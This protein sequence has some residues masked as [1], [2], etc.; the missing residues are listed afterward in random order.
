M[1]TEPKL[2]RP[3]AVLWDMDG[4]LIDQTAAI[5]ECYRQVIVSLGH[6]S[7]D[8]DRIRRSLGGPM[9]STMGLFIEEAQMDEACRAF[10]ALFPSIM[11]EGLI[12]LPGALELIQAFDAAG[13]PQGILTNKH[14]ETARIVSEHCGFSPYMKACIGNTDTEW[15][16]PQAELTNYVLEQIGSSAAGACMIGDSPTDVETAGNAGLPCYTVATGAHTPEELLDSGAA[17]AGQSLHAL[18]DR[19]D[20]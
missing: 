13:I 6:P 19:I 20:W 1:S 10:R 15:H 17:H 14:G 12:I 3:S 11:F 18:L 8:P 16:K 9:A 7:P 5:I 2:P 4:T